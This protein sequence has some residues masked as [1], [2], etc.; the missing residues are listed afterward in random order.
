[1]TDMDIPDLPTPSREA[2]SPLGV[3]RWA[4]VC[5]E[6]ATVEV[7]VK[8]LKLTTVACDFHAEEHRDWADR[9]ERSIN[10]G[11]EPEPE[12]WCPDHLRPTRP[13]QIPYCPSHGTPAARGLEEEL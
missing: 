11:Q 1:M 2:P 7:A 6:D 4:L 8:S 10:P 13:G 5:D 12:C 9:V 3:C